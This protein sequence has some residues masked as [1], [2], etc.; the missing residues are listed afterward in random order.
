MKVNI[1][2]GRTPEMEAQSSNQALTRD[3]ME[4]QVQQTFPNLE[5]KE[6]VRIYG[7]LQRKFD[8]AVDEKSEEINLEEAEKDFIKDAFKTVKF[9]AQ[10]AKYAVRLVDVIDSWDEKKTAEAAPTSTTVSNDDTITPES[11]TGKASKTK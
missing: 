1:D 2:Y 11:R 4:F 8:K 5:G 6:Q 9:P 10:I 7:R 3:Y